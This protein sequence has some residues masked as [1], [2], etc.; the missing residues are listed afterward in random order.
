[1]LPP[2]GEALIPLFFQLIEA[3]LYKKMLDS[4]QISLLGSKHLSFLSRT[5]LSSLTSYSFY[6]FWFSKVHLE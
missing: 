5:M 4:V 1:M 6:Y 2:G 3:L